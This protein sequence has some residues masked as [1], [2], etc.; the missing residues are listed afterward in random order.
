MAEAGLSAVGLLVPIVVTVIICWIAYR[1]TRA[2]PRRLSNAYW[3]L[4]A[5][6]LL[7][8]A[9]S[10]LGVPAAGFAVGALMVV[11]FSAPLLVFCLAVFLILNGVT[12]LRRERRS[13]A[14]LLSLLSGVALLLL[15]VIIVPVLLSGSVWLI[16]ALVVLLLGVGYLAFHFAA[17]LGYSLLYPR[18]VHRRRADWVIVLGA[19]L[20]SDG[21]VTPLLASRL[22]TGLQEFRRRGA[23]TL[24][25]SGGQGADEPRPE[26]EAMAEWATENGADPAAVRREDR[27][28]NTEQNLRFSRELVPAGDEA[29]GGLIVTS[30]YHVL[31]AAI[32]ARRLGLPAQAAG[33]PTAGYYWPSAM[34]REYIALLAA[35]RRLH[36]VLLLLLAI[37]GPAIA[38]FAAFG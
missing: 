11:V 2:E 8:Q 29:A 25:V 38:G 36:L 35:R 16:L 20:S 5:A 15:I 24:I 33:A 9:L 28:E 26:A 4:A 34:I 1:R 27:S 30:N 7:I 31:R 14:N 13:L 23:T 3:L 21:G 10:A 22:R 19:G 12:M 6:L 18:L 32:L 37:P 17:F